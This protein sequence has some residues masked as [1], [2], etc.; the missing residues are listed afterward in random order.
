MVIRKFSPALIALLISLL[1][2][3]VGENQ[4]ISQTINATSVHAT[5]KAPPGEEILPTNVTSTDFPI[6]TLPPP[7][8]NVEFPTQVV[9]YPPEWPTEL[10][11]PEQFVVVE[12]TSGVLP[13][14]DIVGWAA[15]LRIREN[16]QSA[17]SLLSSFFT[18]KGW[19]I[20]EY[21]E[22]DSGGVLMVVERDRDT[23]IAVIDIDVSNPDYAIILS[24]IFP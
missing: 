18:A 5:Q 13:N 7:L 17:A 9:D 1:A 10:R 2:C 23:G 15:K 24:T 6:P 19:Q 21:T 4:S 11:Y 12:T 22:L 16:P 20:A 3:R 14:S 8:T